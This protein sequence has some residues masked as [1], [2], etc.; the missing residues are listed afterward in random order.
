MKVWQ[1]KRFKL[2]LIEMGSERATTGEG[3]VTWMTNETAS[4][5]RTTGL[6]MIFSIFRPQITK[7]TRNW[8]SL[9][10]A[11]FSVSACSELIC[12]PE[13]CWRNS[14]NTGNT[15]SSA[16]QLHLPIAARV[17]ELPEQKR[18]KEIIW[19][20]TLRHIFISHQCKESAENDC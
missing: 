15:S 13:L 18:S 2:T 19:R 7:L 6:P 12:S 3:R 11:T 20:E 9:H 1:N 10:P 17:S 16:H 5:H 4:G 8:F 14:S